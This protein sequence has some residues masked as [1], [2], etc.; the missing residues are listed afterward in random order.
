MA[1]PYRCPNCKTNRSR[2]NFIQQ[3]PAYMKIHPETGEIIEEY[4][5]ENLEAYHF[6]Y[7]GPQYK[8]QC[9]T[10]GSIGEEQSFAAFG[11]MNQ[12]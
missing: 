3:V 7:S 10:C 1:I 9:G 12:P 2:F 5:S 8:L 11:S 6:K 4:T